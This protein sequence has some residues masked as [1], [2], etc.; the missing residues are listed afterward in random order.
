LEG[1]VSSFMHE[2]SGR[3]RV[4]RDFLNLHGRAQAYL[5]ISE[6]P[7]DPSAPVPVPEPSTLL[8]IGSGAV[9]VARQ[10]VNL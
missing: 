9:A 8:L 2:Q 3:G 7:V 6:L 10:W 4:T 5:S 1:S